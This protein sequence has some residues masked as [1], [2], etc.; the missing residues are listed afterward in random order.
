LNSVTR[1]RQPTARL[2]VYD[3]LFTCTVGR[4][5]LG[6][7]SSSSSSSS[8]SYSSSSS[9]SSHFSYSPVQPSSCWSQ[10][11]PWLQKL[12]LRPPRSGNQPDSYPASSSSSSR[13]VVGALSRCVNCYPAAATFETTLGIQSLGQTPSTPT[14]LFSIVMAAAGGS[15]LG[16]FLASKKSPTKRFFRKSFVF[17]DN[18]WVNPTTVTLTSTPY[19]MAGAVTML[20]N[21]Y[22]LRMNFGSLG[23]GIIQ[24]TQPANRNSS[25][26]GRNSKYN[27]RDFE[28][29]CMLDLE[30]FASSFCDSDN[31]AAALEKECEEVIA[32]WGSDNRAKE[33]MGSRIPIER[34]FSMA[35]YAW[36]GKTRKEESEYDTQ[37]SELLSQ[38]DLRVLSDEVVPLFRHLG[39]HSSKSTS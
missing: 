11:L 13:V 15:N 28:S 39:L 8:S 12:D 22:K 36:E 10:P 21:M 24:T 29:I 34:T 23:L 1:R 4:T 32:E 38:K 5:A 26:H 27:D 9:S 14:S 33:K 18:N 16:A 2:P 17:R 20:H 19:G 25:N 7:S 35:K 6:G 30:A 31:L 3:L 37:L